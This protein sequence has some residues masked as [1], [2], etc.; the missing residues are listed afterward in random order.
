MSSEDYKRGVIDATEPLPSPRGLLDCYANSKF[1]DRRKQLLTKKVTKWV[2]VGISV[3]NGKP[4]AQGYFQDSKESA[5]ANKTSDALDLGFVGVFPI[6]I[7]VE[8]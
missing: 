1:S 7:E 3:S 5:L 2:A 4:Y 8:I 6:E